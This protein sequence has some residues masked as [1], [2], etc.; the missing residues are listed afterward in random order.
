MSSRQLRKLQK[1]KELEKTNDLPTRE[2]DESEQDEGPTPI[3]VKPRVSLFAA[4]GGEDEHDEQ[5]DDD[6]DNQGN[7]QQ[8]T[9][10]QEQE[11]TISPST[12][13]K[14]KKKKKKKVK[15]KPQT[16]AA[17]TAAGDE[18]EDE[19]EIDK[20]IKELKL[21]T[22]HDPEQS[23]SGTAGEPGRRINELLS[24]NTYHLKAINEMRNLFGRD[25]IESANAEGEQEQNRRRRG[26]V[27]QQVDLETFLRSLPGAK[28]LPEVSLRRN[29]FIHGREHWPRA[30]AG[31]LMMKQMKKAADGLSVEY[32]YVHDK[33]Y[34]DIQSV[35]FLY[36]GVGDPMRMVHLLREVRKYCP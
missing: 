15:A 28:K 36:I 1:Q 33:N 27:Q 35:F 4:L 29:V 19:D 32:A 6:N 24:I 7:A 30:T 18:N 13:K 5:D 16:V 3:P 8:A 14:S 22:Q 34:D 21:T 25:I 2:S 23:S 26:P 17:G 12:L 20:A 9:S 31:G 10:R 11:E